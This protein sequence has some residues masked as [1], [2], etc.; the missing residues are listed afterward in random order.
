VS[1]VT[2]SASGSA[3]WTI[4]AGLDCICFGAPGQRTQHAGEVSR[5]L[6]T[7]AIAWLEL[8][9]ADFEC[10]R[11]EGQRLGRTPFVAEHESKPV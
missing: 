10:A 7:V 5:D 2:Q 9:Y 3:S 11:D 4:P 6:D 1:R 8:T